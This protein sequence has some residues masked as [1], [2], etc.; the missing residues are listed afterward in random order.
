MLGL[1]NFKYYGPELFGK[2][3]I[4]KYKLKIV[5]NMLKSGLDFVDSSL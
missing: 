3:L 4:I 2:C 1:D 5:F